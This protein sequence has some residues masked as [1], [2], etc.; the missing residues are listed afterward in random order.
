MR[1]PDFHLNL[2]ALNEYETIHT[3]IGQLKNVLYHLLGIE[4]FNA[5]ISGKPSQIDSLAVAAA[6]ERDFLNI[7][8]LYGEN[9]PQ[10][11][12]SRLKLDQSIRNFER[13]TNIPWPL[14]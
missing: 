14:K 7:S 3:R 5:F 4:K 10:A 1:N 13:E 12:S 8:S 11:R 6:A 2:S 9:S